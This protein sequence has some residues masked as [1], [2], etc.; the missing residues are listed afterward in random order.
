MLTIYYIV[1]EVD[2]SAIMLYNSRIVR[3]LTYLQK[4]PLI[5]HIEDQVLDFSRNPWEHLF[6]LE[7]WNCSESEEEDSSVSSDKFSVQSPVTPGSLSSSNSD[8]TDNDCDSIELHT[9]ELKLD[10]ESCPLTQKLNVAILYL[11]K[12]VTKKK[13]QI[14]YLK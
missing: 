9:D 6:P 11:E 5:K 13:R 3:P 1:W 8:L 4:I 14:I 2:Y 10:K 12:F 7:S